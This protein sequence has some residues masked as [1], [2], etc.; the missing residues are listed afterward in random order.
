MWSQCPP[1]A[2]S[3]ALSMISQRQCMSPRESVDPMYMPG[4]LRTASSPSR[5][6]RWWAVYSDAD[7]LVAVFFA[8]VT[9]TS[10]RV[11]GAPDAARQA[12]R[13]AHGPVGRKVTIR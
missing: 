12:H 10:G 6:W 13:P 9:V 8:A 11:S 2:S 7:L 1:S 4:R 3:T 5:T